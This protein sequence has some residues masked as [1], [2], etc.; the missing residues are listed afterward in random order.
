MVVLIIEVIVSA[1]ESPLVT[2]SSGAAGVDVMTAAAGTVDCDATVVCDTVAV[3]GGT[4]V[5]A[6]F[7]AGT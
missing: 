1:A 3:F 7:V 5:A 4:V 2:V 6:A